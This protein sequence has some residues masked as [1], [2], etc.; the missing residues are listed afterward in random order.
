MAEY[1]YAVDIKPP[2][3]QDG[4]DVYKVLK[5]ICDYLF[6]QREGLE[7]TLHNLNFK[8]FNQQKLKDAGISIDDDG[9]I[10]IGE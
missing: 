10:H 9:K 8:N 3:L 5:E 6:L 2:V 4:D 7:Y 1:Q